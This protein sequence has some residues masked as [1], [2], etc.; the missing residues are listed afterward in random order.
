MNLVDFK[1]KNE[2]KRLSK[3]SSFKSEIFEL[4]ENRYS[5]VSI[6]KFLK[7][8]GVQTTFQNLHI[9]IKKNHKTEKNKIAIKK[10]EEQT[11]STSSSWEPQLKKNNNPILEHLNKGK[12]N[13]RD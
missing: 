5:L 2:P 3:L 13:E 1:K 11:A 6:Q 7:E 8:N 10:V 4:Y 9:F 12:T